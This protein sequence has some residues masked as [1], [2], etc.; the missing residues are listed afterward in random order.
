MWRS[1]F[2]SRSASFGTAEVG[3]GAAGAFWASDSR[4]LKKELRSTSKALSGF[5]CDW[6]GTPGGMSGKEVRG[7]EAVSSA[8]LRPDSE[9]GTELRKLLIDCTRLWCSSVLAASDRGVG[10]A[11]EGCADVHWN[12]EPLKLAAGAALGM[13]LGSTWRGLNAMPTVSVSEMSESPVGL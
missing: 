10:I 11:T 2:G 13:L 5:P 4:R 6:A 7:K 12:G 8:G 3:G 9:V 1:G